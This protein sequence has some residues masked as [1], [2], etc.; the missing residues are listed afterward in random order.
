M[1][2]RS[3]PL[4]RRIMRIAT[5]P[6]SVTAFSNARHS[7]LRPPPE[8]LGLSCRL[9]QKNLRTIWRLCHAVGI[10]QPIRAVTA[11]A[12]QMT[13]A[14]LR[15]RGKLH[16]F[17]Q[18]SPFRRSRA[19][20]PQPMA[21]LSTTSPM[22]LSGTGGSASVFFNA[23]PCCSGLP[24]WWDAARTT[25]I[26]VCVN[27]WAGSICRLSGICECRSVRCGFERR[28]FVLQ[29]CRLARCQCNRVAVG[30]RQ[31]F[32]EEPNGRSR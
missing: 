31:P 18:Q 2:R 9:C 21:R 5:A 22:P 14:R 25:P 28:G 30:L 32:W 4:G 23:T 3:E 8:V 12:R 7:T 24:N 20:I 15:D 29:V 19:L 13:P 1:T 16:S 10:D 11:E 6:A 27:Q 17:S 26:V